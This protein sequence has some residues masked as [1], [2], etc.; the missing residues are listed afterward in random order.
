MEACTGQSEDFCSCAFSATVGFVDDN[1]DNPNVTSRRFKTLNNRLTSLAKR[2]TTQESEAE[3]PV[4]YIKSVLRAHMLLIDQHP[5]IAKAVLELLYDMVFLMS[6]LAK[7]KV[8]DKPLNSNTLQQ[9][10][11]NALISDIKKK[12]KDAENA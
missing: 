9:C 7:L 8:I 2:F 4:N 12:L 1:P 5:M 6:V 3:E 10:Q 11:V